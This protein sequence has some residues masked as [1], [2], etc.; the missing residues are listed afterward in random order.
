M[1]LLQWIFI[2]FRFILLLCS[3]SDLLLLKC[4]LSDEDTFYYDS[5]ASS[6]N[7]IVI[8]AIAKQ[9]GFLASVCQ[10]LNMVHNLLLYHH[11]K[12]CVNTLCTAVARWWTWS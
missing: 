1:Y 8:H 10:V 12:P 6:N 9:T 11:F 5:F 4:V 2:L 3:I 7:K